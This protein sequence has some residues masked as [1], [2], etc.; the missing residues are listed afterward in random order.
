MTVARILALFALAGTLFSAAN[1]DLTDPMTGG[2][3]KSVTQQMGIDQ[4][5]GSIVPLSTRV[6]D[7]KGN[8]MLLRQV[9]GQKPV[10]LMPIFYNCQSACTLVFNGVFDVVRG[11]RK[12]LKLGVDYDIV[13]ISIHPKETH[14]D[15]AKK[16]EAVM[17]VLERMDRLGPNRE[18]EMG[19]RFLT[20]KP[21]GIAA[22]TRAVGFRYGYN[23]ERDVVTH[24]A[25]IMVL[26]PDGV[27]SKYFYGVSYVPKLMDGAL[28]DARDKR[29]GQQAETILFGCLEFDPTRSRYVLVVD[30][31]LKIAGTGT[32]IVLLM[33]IMYWGYRYRQQPIVKNSTPN[34]GENKE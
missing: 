9:I 17:A 6:Y 4:K 24:P 10:I 3:R 32:A 34:Q 16:K 15:A 13:A 25:G 14:V 27:V 7:E 23:A 18:G 31:V 30:R 22:I 21:E 33:T 8:E 1:A 28:K 2:V 20:A 5:L 29:I 11:F 12:N 19:W 26:T